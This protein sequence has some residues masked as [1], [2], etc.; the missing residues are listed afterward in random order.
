MKL[1]QEPAASAGLTAKP[2][3]AKVSSSLDPGIAKSAGGRS[4][5]VLIVDDHPVVRKGPVNCLARH[6]RV[7]VVGEAQDGLEALTKARE[8]AP[9]LVL[10]D[11][12]LPKL[13][14]LSA[15]EILRRENPRIKVIILTAHNPAQYSSRIL[16]SGAAGFL[17]K[18]AS[19]DELVQAIEAVALG[20]CH[21]DSEIVQ[22]ALRGLAESHEMSS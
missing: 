3:L 13:D 2:K 1:S 9:D 12:D 15:T 16:Q 18:R 4:I 21:F 6:K 14:G 5:R 10:M 17:S 7:V 19:L 8:L 22:S 11:I 20:S